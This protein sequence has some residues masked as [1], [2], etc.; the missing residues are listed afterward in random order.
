MPKGLF[1]GK[2]RWIA[3]IPLLIVTICWA[4]GLF[5]YVELTLGDSIYQRP[6]GAS[7]KIFVI[8][9]DEHTLAEYG[10]FST[11]S[12][13]GVAQVV[14]KLMENKDSAPA[15]IGID[16]EFFGT[17]DPL[18]DAQLVAACKNAG[19]VVL[20]SSALIGTAVEGTTGNFF[21]VNKPVLMDRPFPALDAVAAS[22]HVN[23]NMDIDGVVRRSLQIL[24]H[25][26]ETIYSFGAEVYRAYR[27]QYSEVNLDKN[28]EW[29]IP[30]SARPYGYYGMPGSGASLSKVISGEYP[31]S[32]FK[33]SIVLIGAYAEGMMDA[34]DS[35]V[36]KTTRM[37]GVEIHANILQALLE[38]KQLRQMPT[39]YTALICAGFWFAAIFV[40]WHA[41]FRVSLP[42]TVG[43]C[44]AYVGMA[45]GLAQFGWMIA[46]IG[47]ELGL[48]CMMVVFF[49]VEFSAIW[50][51]KRRLISNFSRYLPR[52][53]AQRVAERGEDT[54]RLG[55][56]KRHIAVVFV[57]I[58]GFT[59]L[60]ERLQPEELVLLLNRFLNLTTS[61]IFSYGG[62]V[63]KFIGDATM[64]LFNAPDLMQDYE[65]C[66]IQAAFD[67]V[68]RSVGLT[69]ELKALGFEGIGFG[70]GVN[71]GHAVVGNV[72]TEFRMEYTAIGDAVNTAARLESQAKAGEV[73]ISSSIHDRLA[74]R[75]ECEYL[76]ERQLK[77][78]AAP[79]PIW[80]V[81]GI[82]QTAVSPMKT[83]SP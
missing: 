40:L 82:K 61:C 67:M 28:G 53:I 68:T 73:L 78:K 51:D 58:R 72:G 20:A 25:E 52:E 66:A 71:A 50:R 29:V 49:G 7:N 24:K 16:I 65:F 56:V 79:V 42:V 62:T 3:I 70:V 26:D 31:A 63:D 1:T 33:D 80:R 10:P 23:I 30:Y 15:V 55:G 11:W 60:S 69:E 12:R 32:V 77:G 36:S 5:K 17:K 6:T 14:N 18:G 9:I 37:Y 54:L 44:L 2:I 76:G 35:P 74:D 57:D 75:I 43:L 8:G 47:P 64:A 45:L 34:F 46:I 4:C 81:T 39:V 59:P 13:E 22:G 19:N 83:G 21:S 27:G 38:G 48:F 41:R